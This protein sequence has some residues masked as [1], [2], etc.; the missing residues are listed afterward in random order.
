MV[1]MGELDYIPRRKRRFYRDQNKKLMKHLSKQIKKA[2]GI[3][4]IEKQKIILSLK[5]QLEKA[6][7]EE[8]K[9]LAAH[10]FEQASY[11]RDDTR[12]LVF[13]E[14]LKYQ[15]RGKE[16]SN[17]EAD[18][19]AES[20]YSQLK[21]RKEAQ[22]IFDR[23]EEK[24]RKEREKLERKRAKRLFVKERGLPPSKR[25]ELKDLGVFGIKEPEKTGRIDS[26]A[27]VDKIKE[28]LSKELGLG[29]EKETESIFDE[30]EK[31]SEESG[32]DEFSME[33]FTTDFGLE[34]KKKKDQKAL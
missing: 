16:L 18:E 27:K 24:K 28:E 22:K 17:K 19:I 21:E 4:E 26:G 34:K 20:I 11:G 23:L 6:R 31:V 7:E 1:F 3:K 12:E 8:I 2:G 33:G 29:K 9:D 32:K 13:K 25:R 5:R 15:G 14:V 30:L 10:L